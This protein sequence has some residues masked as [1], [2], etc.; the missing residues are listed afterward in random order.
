MPRLEAKPENKK[1]QGVV[2]NIEHAESVDKASKLL[3]EL[4]R[5]RGQQVSIRI[6]ATTSIEVPSKLCKLDLRK[7]VERFIYIHQIDRDKLHKQALSV[8]EEKATDTN[9]NIIKEIVL[10]EV[11]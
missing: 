1:T 5:K 8:L 3:A 4:K 11:I 6:T 2:S 10:E 7:K 9:L